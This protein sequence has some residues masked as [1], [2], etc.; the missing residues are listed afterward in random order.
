MGNKRAR[1]RINCLALICGTGNPSPTL[2][3]QQHICEQE[4]HQK[5]QCVHDGGNK[6]AGHYCRVKAQHLGHHRQ[7][8]THKFGAHHRHRQSQAYHRIDQQ[9][10]V[11]IAHEHSVDQPDLCKADHAQRNTAQDGC[12][13]FF[14]DHPANIV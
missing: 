9:R 3:T 13:Q 4:V 6:G 7:N 12:P 1:Q 2:H 8:A 14:P 11:L 10:D 5:G